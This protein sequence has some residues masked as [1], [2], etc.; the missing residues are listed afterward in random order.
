MGNVG[1]THWIGLQL[2]KYI[3]DHCQNS[4]EKSNLMRTLAWKLFRIDW[5]I[6]NNR[7]VEGLIYFGTNIKLII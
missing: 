4:E 3:E 2:E 6:R 1:D 5:N 7:F